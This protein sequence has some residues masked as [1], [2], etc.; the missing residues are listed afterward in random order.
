[1]PKC[2][3]PTIDDLRPI[4]LLPT[5]IKVL[6]QFIIQSTK[7]DIFRNYG[8]NQFGFR[9]LS[10]TI[11]AL[12]AMEDFITSSFDRPD[13][14][15]V[16]VVTYD[17]SKAFDKLMY[18]VIISRLRECDM[19]PSVVDWFV[20]YFSNRK[21]FVKIGKEKSSLID[22]TSGVPQGSVIGPFLFSLVAGSFY[23]EFLNCKV[24]KY[25]DD[26]TMC[27]AILKKSENK[28]LLDLHNSFMKRT[29]ELGLTVNLKKC[30][31]FYVHFRTHCSPVILSNV[32]FVNDLKIL[33]VIL[34]KTLSW[35][36]HIDSTV[37]AASRRLYVLRVLKDHVSRHELISV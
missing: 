11:C 20:N 21:Q 17:L 18:N 16:Q 29:D 8:K 7:H 31:T 25:A 34:D 2:P 9:P 12:I 28:H 32:L 37:K 3:A 5:P 24:F 30:K 19:S 22:V 23:T 13:V 27:A 36:S 15:G 33:G 1:M 35:N 26:F 6:E 4:S 10:S 14:E